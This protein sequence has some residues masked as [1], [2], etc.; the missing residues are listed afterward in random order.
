MGAGLA[1]RRI[2]FRGGTRQIDAGSAQRSAPLGGWWLTVTHSAHPVLR[3][4]QTAIA[5]VVT[6]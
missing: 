2:G 5:R 4:A 3:R 1:G 6:V